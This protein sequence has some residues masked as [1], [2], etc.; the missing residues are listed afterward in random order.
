MEKELRYELGKL[1]PGVDIFPASAPIE[2]KPPF[3]I[4]HRDST[5]WKKTLDGYFDGGE[6]I[7]FIVNVFG[8]SYE[9][10]YRMRSELE[11]LVRKMPG[12]YIGENEDLAINDLDL[13]GIA[14]IFEPKLGLYR[15]IV[16]FTVHI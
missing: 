14:E 1:F 7:N 12:S 15:G 13:G 5:L 10:M 6:E 8:R 4:Y 16:D 2:K 3:V 9:Q 11:G